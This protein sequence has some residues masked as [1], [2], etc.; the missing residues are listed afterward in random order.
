VKKKRVGR[1]WIS[2]VCD[3]YQPLEKKYM[4]TKRC[5]AILVENGW[6]FTVQTK[7]PLVLR[8]IG[9]VKR[10]KDVEVG[11]TITTA[12]EKIRKLFEPGAPPSRRRIEALAKLHL[13]GIRT[14]AMVARSSQAP[15]A[16]E[17]A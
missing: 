9:I 4:L 8:D 17:R 15:R 14:F 5:L 1:V 13:E 6:P 7:S 3:P 12:D 11:F 16:G 2:G 10:S